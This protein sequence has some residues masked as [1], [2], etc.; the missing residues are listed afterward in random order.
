MKKR[1]LL[2]ALMAVAMMSACMTFAV[3]GAAIKGNKSSKIYHKSDCKH[4]AAKGS[5]ESFASETDAQKSGY[6]ACKKCG[7]P[8]K[9]KKNDPKKQK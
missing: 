4:Y 1:S 2:K 7:K 5:T 9:S 6:K 3:N 8:S